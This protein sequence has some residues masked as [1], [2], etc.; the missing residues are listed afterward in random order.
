MFLLQ[1]KTDLHHQI[2]HADINNPISTT[3]NRLLCYAGI[4]VKKNLF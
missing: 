4:K 1:E 2:L 3:F